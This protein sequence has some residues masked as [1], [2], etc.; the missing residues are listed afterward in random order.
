MEK[1]KGKRIT[2]QIV[3]NGGK[4]IGAGASA[5]ALYGIC[6]MGAQ[7][8]G[9]PIDG[10]ILGA[11]CSLGHSYGKNIT[12]KA[13]IAATL[14]GAAKIALTGNV[15]LGMVTALATGA[16]VAIV[17]GAEKLVRLAIN[18]NGIKKENTKSV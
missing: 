14:A 10:A 16:A 17:S 12:M 3:K 9:N 7:P 2:G 18:K 1:S 5:A 13:A 8:L 15:E 11:A 4:L 6:G